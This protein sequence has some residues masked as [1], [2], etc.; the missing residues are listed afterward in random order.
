M[1]AL[2]SGSPAG[3]NPA[4]ARYIGSIPIAGVGLFFLEKRKPLGKEKL[5]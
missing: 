5:K 4:S 1:P 2:G 3:L